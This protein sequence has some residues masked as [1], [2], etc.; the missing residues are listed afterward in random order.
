M[1]L[2]LNLFVTDIYF[3]SHD[4]LENK[5]HNIVNFHTYIFFG[6]GQHY[7]GSPK[8]ASS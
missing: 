3:E 7:K 4:N 5:N 8:L 6:N 2:W 1:E